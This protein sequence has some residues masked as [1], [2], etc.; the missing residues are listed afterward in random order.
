MCASTDRIRSV[1]E[2]RE[3]VIARVAENNAPRAI[4]SHGSLTGFVAVW[5]HVEG[6]TIDP[7]AAAALGVEPG[8]TVLVAPQ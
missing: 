3:V 5:G 4:V 1:A 2:A 7:V 8:Q 6:D